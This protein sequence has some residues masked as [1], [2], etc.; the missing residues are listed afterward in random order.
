MIN[1]LQN[2]EAALNYR[3]AKN[4]DIFLF[5]LE[6]RTVIVKLNFQC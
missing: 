5:V 3:Q 6:S 2:Y 1:K 4:V